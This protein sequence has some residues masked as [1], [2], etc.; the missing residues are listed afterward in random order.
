[1]IVQSWDTANKAGKMNGFSVCTTWGIAGRSFYL[2]QVHRMA[3]DL[4]CAHNDS[5]RTA[6]P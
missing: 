6:S 3:H 4:S 2:L 5:D 1:M